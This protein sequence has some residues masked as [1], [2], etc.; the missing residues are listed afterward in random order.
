MESEEVAPYAVTLLSSSDDEN[1]LLVANSYDVD[2][3]WGY[4][5]LSANHVRF[6]PRLVVQP[7]CSKGN[8]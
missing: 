3:H 4:V 6:A 8:Q 5:L 1:G 7:S 2:K